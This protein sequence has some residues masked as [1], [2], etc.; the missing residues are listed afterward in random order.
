MEAI[1]EDGTLDMSEM[2]EYAAVASGYSRFLE[3]DVVVAKITPCF[4]N[5]K[6]ALIRG[7]ATGIG[8]GTTELHVL[9]PSGL[10][11][12]SFLR[13]ITADPAFRTLG[14]QAMVGAAGQKRVPESFIRD[15]P[16]AL[17]PL[18][19]QRAIAADLDRETTRI[20]A[21]LA[22]KTSFVERLG[23]KRRTLVSEAVTRGLD[24]AAPR[25]DSGVPW[26]GEIPAHWEVERGRWLFTERDNRSATGEE[27]M[28]TVSHITGVTK[29][30]EKDVNMFEAASTVGYKICQPGDLAINT[31]WAWMGAMGVSPHHGI[32]SPA[33]HVY[34]PSP[35]LDSAYVDALV[36][37]RHFV[38]EVTRYSKGVW[39][40]RLRLYPAEFFNVL[41]PV[42]PVSEQRAIVAEIER[43]TQ[44]IDAVVR[45]TEASVTLLQERRGAL[46]SATVTGQR[47]VV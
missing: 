23:E 16:V 31:L 11:N 9:T 24:P 20:D 3:G 41:F 33:Y 2:R 39:S 18:A 17:P 40:S 21:L 7:T 44:K 35:R 45:A 5:G 30:S 27:E 47:R 32:V 1:G 15:F 13:Y 10:L 26:L 12:G 4:E 22:A 25:R 34:T 37:T 14:V 19:E 43:Q 29:R 36:R 46:I 38:T 6:G 28:L 8:F 42:P